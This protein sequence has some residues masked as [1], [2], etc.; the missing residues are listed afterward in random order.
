MGM[1]IAGRFIGGIAC[2]Q[3]LV[4]VPIYIAEV[5]PPTQRGYFVGLQGLMVAIVFAIANWVGYT[6]SF[7]SGQVTWRVPLAIQIPIPILLI[8][9]V[10]FVP[11]S[12]CWLI[13]QDRHDEAESILLQLR[14][15]SEADGLVA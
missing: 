13:Q 7:A 2:G 9:S 14:G 8:V 1:M 11:F 6:G 15:G 5:A 3:L 10:I 12:P 4:V